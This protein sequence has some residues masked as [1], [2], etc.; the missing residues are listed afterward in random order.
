MTDIPVVAS[1][2]NGVTVTPQV[3]T[4]TDTI[5]PGPYSFVLLVVRT[6]GTNTYSGT[7]DDPTSQA[8]AGNLA[9]A[10]NPDI[11]TGVIPINTTKSF[12]LPANRFKDSNGKINITSGSTFAGTTVEAYGF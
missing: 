7:I 10:F 11:I 4:A 3:P 12:L 6:G 2:V 8:P 1:N 5:T 9:G